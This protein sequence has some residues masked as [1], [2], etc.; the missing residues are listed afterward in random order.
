MGKLKSC[1]VSENV[2]L[3]FRSYFSRTQAVC[4]NNCVSTSRIVGSRIG[5]GTI[6][7]PLFL[8]FILMM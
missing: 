7:G 1:G 4:F 3:W 5:Q 8:Y 2:L 6:L